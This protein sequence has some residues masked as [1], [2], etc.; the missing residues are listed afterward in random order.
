MKKIF[1]FI[2]L[3]YSVVCE[4]QNIKGFVID[5]TTNKALQ[6]AVI[7][8]K[9]T[10]KN[11]SSDEQG[12]FVFQ[13]IPSENYT[14]EITFVGY[15][16]AI[17]KDVMVKKGADTELNVALQVSD[18]ELNTVL[19][20]G[21]RN[22]PFA[23]LQTKYVL[24][25]EQ[26]LR[27]PA[28]FN[29]PARLAMQAPGV[30]NDNDLANGL[31]IR[32]YSPDAMQWRLEG[33][34]IVNPNHLA[35]ASSFN[36]GATANAGGT[37]ALSSQMLGTSSLITGGFTGEYNNVISG[38]M[39]MRLR[40][41]N[42]ERHRFT[43]Q[44]SLVGLDFAAEGPFSKKSKASYLVNY[45]YSTVGLLQKMGVPLSD[46]II[47][48]QD[49]AWNI[50]LPIGK[51]SNL[52]VFGMLGNSSNT[53]ETKKDTIATVR[54][55]TDVYFKDKLQVFGASFKNSNGLEMVFVRSST[56]P[57]LVRN[58]YSNDFMAKNTVSELYSQPAINSFK[59]SRIKQKSIK[60]AK[61][62]G[63]LI[64]HYEYGLNESI[65]LP[66]IFVDFVRKG[67]KYN[68]QLSFSIER[69]IIPN[70][71]NES[72]FGFSPKYSFD[73]Y[74]KN[75]SKIN[76][77][78]AIQRRF[79]D[80]I[81]SLQSNLSYIKQNN[82]Q[83]LVLRTYFHV[84]TDDLSGFSGL[85]NIGDYLYSPTQTTYNNLDGKDMAYGIEGSF[86][87][88]LTHN[89]SY[90]LVGSLYENSNSFYD[91]NYAF[92]GTISKEWIKSNNKT[93]IAVLSMLNGSRYIN[94]GDFDANKDS[95]IIIFSQNLNFYRAV[96]IQNYFRTDLRLYRQRDRKNWSSTLSL[97]IQNVTNQKNIAFQYNDLIAKKIL[98]KYQN[99][100]IPILGWRANF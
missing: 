17:V 18:N 7:V 92:K 90:N 40:N 12:V 93:G 25:V 81:I 65:Y 4:A 9:N 42:T 44:A 46:E 100:L 27:T 23:A 99:G 59:I 78:T 84:N 63:L 39:D 29:D 50:Q 87:Q 1:I 77:S 85:S 89:I 96:G 49:L 11:T 74:L 69:L 37:N 71:S 20:N 21:E 19:V 15:A 3:L 54:D 51:K 41:G 88:N 70:Y 8:L 64:T 57:S 80:E 36:D 2:I 67:K 32:G 22:D 61:K 33:V 6:G 94:A 31:S 28:A 55:L 66:R 10:D 26:T 86:E 43:T 95:Y 97:D 53:F 30:V 75:N 98:T 79:Q 62:I 34:E 13:E 68:S 16:K 73:Y 83:K 35:N 52:K 14:A 60:K 5:A 45:R 48:F 76:F 56:A 91:G 24:G 58:F 72:G 38:A 47:S 82:D